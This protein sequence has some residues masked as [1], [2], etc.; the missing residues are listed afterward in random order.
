ME[1]YFG[2][3]SV[4]NAF[5]KNSYFWIGP[6]FLKKDWYGKAVLPVE[7]KYSI[8]HQQ[9]RPDQIQLKIFYAD[10]VQSPIYG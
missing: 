2:S 5:D 7:W 6:D 3:M 8:R 9:H 4:L 1:L 10:K